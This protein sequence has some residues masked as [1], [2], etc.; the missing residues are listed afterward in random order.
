MAESAVFLP[1]RLELKVIPPGE[2]LVRIYPD[3]IHLADNVDGFVVTDAIDEVTLA[4]D[5][6]HSALDGGASEGNALDAWTTICDAVG[7]HRATWLVRESTPTNLNMARA[8]AP[9]ALPT[10]PV[11]SRTSRVAVLGLPARFRLRVELHDGTE[12]RMDGAPVPSPL[13]MGVPPLGAPTDPSADP[14]EI[15]LWGDLSWMVSFPDAEAVGMAMRM[16]L[17]STSA[18]YAGLRVVS[19]S[20]VGAS[21]GDLETLL[22]SHVGSRGL[23]FVEDGTATNN[24]DSAAAGFSSAFG[25]QASFGH[26]WAW[27]LQNRASLPSNTV[28][29]RWVAALQLSNPAPLRYASGAEHV[30]EPLA[31]ACQELVMDTLFEP[32]MGCVM[33]PV[34]EVETIAAI[35]REARLFATQYVRPAGPYSAIRIGDTPYGLLPVCSPGALPSFDGSPTSWISE[36]VAVLRRNAMM[37]AE[38]SPIHGR[39]IT[40]RIARS[41]HPNAYLVAPWNAVA[42]S[43]TH[44]DLATA[45][46]NLAGNG[47]SSVEPT[48]YSQTYGELD[49][50][51]TALEQWDITGRTGSKPDFPGNPD[52]V[53]TL[54][55]PLQDRLLQLTSDAFELH[56]QIVEITRRRKFPDA[57]DWPSHDYEWTSD[58]DDRIAAGIGDP[59]DD[60]VA[61]ELARGTGS[62]RDT[63]GQTIRD[64]LSG[65]GTSI[66]SLGAQRKLLL[67]WEKDQQAITDI[68]QLVWVEFYSP[69]TRTAQLDLLIEQ[70]LD[71][72]P[73]SSVTLG[74]IH[75]HAISLVDSWTG[76]DPYDEAGF[77]TVSDWTLLRATLDPSDSYGLLSVSTGQEQVN[78]FLRAAVGSVSYRLDAWLT[79][80]AMEQ[81]PAHSTLTVGAFGVAFEFPPFN[82]LPASPRSEGY[83]LAPT[84]PAAATAAVL[85]SGWLAHEQEVGHGD[86]SQDGSRSALAI[87]LTGKR[88]RWATRV[89]RALRDGVELGPLLGQFIE[90]RL[91][92]DGQST[93]IPDLRTAIMGDAKLPV[94]GLLA[95]R[96]AYQSVLYTEGE[97]ADEDLPA[98]TSTVHEVL[99]EVACDLDGINDLLHA[100]GVHHL[101]ARQLDRAQVVLSAIV[102]G[103]AV[104]PASFEVLEPAQGAGAER[105]EWILAEELVTSLH[106]LRPRSMAS[107]A[108][109]AWCDRWVESSWLV[110]VENDTTSAAVSLTDLGLDSLDAV[111]E[112][113]DETALLVRAASYAGMS[114]TNLRWTETDHSQWRAVARALADMMSRLRPLDDDE[115]HGDRDWET[116]TLRVDDALQRWDNEMMPHSGVIEED[117]EGLSNLALDLLD[118]GSRGIAFLIADETQEEEARRLV[119]VWSTLRQDVMS[120]RFDFDDAKIAADSEPDP[121]VKATLR[122]K[123]AQIGVQILQSMFG[124]GLPAPGAIRLDVP[125]RNP[126]DAP[127]HA[128]EHLARVRNALTPLH[129]ASTLSIGMELLGE[130][131]TTPQVLEHRL[132]TDL[133]VERT[134]LCG[135]PPPGAWEGYRLDSWSEALPSDV[136]SPALA[137]HVDVPASQA[138]NVLALATEPPAGWNEDTAEE[139]VSELAKLVKLRGV[140]PNELEVAPGLGSDAGL[141]P[142]TLGATLP[143]GS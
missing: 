141:L 95:L 55:E 35:T 139:L 90:Q 15:A 121:D 63:N 142:A 47:M 73:E 31:T 66:E 138:P 16:D 110:E 134:L 19:V 99:A 51:L 2:L 57:W 34:A 112:A 6:W 86:A 74:D 38:L 3:D 97:D 65:S 54:G 88:M 58:L 113:K 125:V 128:L 132:D 93:E 5:F 137:M 11:G 68:L 24:T 78:H 109:A 29:E 79:G 44:S 98:L 129:L 14:A 89:A 75:D 8:G 118:Y 85:R 30:R 23:A 126:S 117:Q 52:G 72:T 124:G 140:G 115:R 50:F 77:P 12:V 130:G 116:L 48:V 61:R 45:F 81:L 17:S 96:G 106:S 80:F 53:H 123:Q 143:G 87:E 28:A 91:H 49:D 37:V 111:L 133:G 46:S 70:L 25:V 60:E 94:D 135:A 114:T 7:V 33:D 64:L 36:I 82:T 131:P 105:F 22:A 102:P 10:M 18:L 119:Q 56:E 67:T 104:M 1:V 76:G 26:I 21:P 59:P 108:L 32:S 69:S 20:G 136:A 101:L 120:L 41:A 107:P 92:D 42:P 103:A 84:G 127:E 27:I 9:P 4:S 40:Q 62:T 122:R 43:T 71:A 100:E 13:Y 83:V 39:S